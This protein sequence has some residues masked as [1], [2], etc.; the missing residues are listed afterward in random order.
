MALGITR[1]VRISLNSVDARALAQFYIDTL[2]FMNLED[3]ARSAHRLS[4][5]LGTT[6]IDIVSTSG[7]P[8]PGDVPGWSPLFQHCAIV[9]RDMTQAVAHLKTFPGWTAISQE[10]PEKLPKSSGGVT[11]FKFRDPEGHPLE[12]LEFPQQPR[13]QPRADETRL[14]LD[15]DHSAISVASTQRSVAFYAALGLH[16]GAASLNFGPEQARLDSVPDAEVE[17]TALEFVSKNKPHI[18]LLRYR[19]S[20]DRTGACAQPDDIAASRLVCAVSATDTI[21]R[22]CQRFPER[23]LKQENATAL[24]RDPDGHLIEIELDGD[25]AL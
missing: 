4:L 5:V 2:G 14:F 9:T 10:G 3:K 21:A 1:L 13:E 23:V 22:L 18:E 16:V 15:I 25:H 12:F 17:V 8:Y 19:G 6:R 11:A 24:F 7:A 20:Y